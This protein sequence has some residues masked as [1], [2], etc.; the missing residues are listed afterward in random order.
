MSPRPDAAARLRR[1]LTVIPWIVDHQGA[2]L[3]ELAS[4]FGITVSELERDLELVPFCGLPPYSPDRLI[5]CS[6]VDG[7]VFLRFAEYF[8]RPLRLTPAEGFAL[9]ATGRALLAVSGADAGG[10][11]A[12]ALDKLAGVLGDVE[13][14]AIE[15]GPARF[16]EPL[17]RAAQAAERVEIDYYAF[18]RDAL[19]TRRIDPR[20]V[21]ASL[22]QWYVDAYCHQAQDDRLFRVDRVQDL[23]PT[24]EHFESG[25]GPRRGGEAA[26]ITADGTVFHPRPTDPRVILRLSPEARWVVES[27]PTEEIAEEADGRLRV[28]LVAS[29]RPWLERLLLRLGPLAEVLGPDDAKEWGAAAARRLLVNYR[30]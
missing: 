16:L 22:G 17:R 30:D 20:A 9:L 24:G 18:G 5:D 3:E 14:M 6:I 1:L 8:A 2:R 15:L 7:R 29:E 11:L 10:S 27:Y 4:R 19:T 23:R 28:V 25:R 26:E 21:F 13:G 12:T